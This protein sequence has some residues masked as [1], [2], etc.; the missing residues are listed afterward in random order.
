VKYTD[1]EQRRIVRAAEA[2]VKADLRLVAEHLNNGVPYYTTAKERNA[3]HDQFV[4]VMVRIWGSRSTKKA[5]R[6]G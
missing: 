2:Y 6:N 4:Q 1:K 5:V 3:R